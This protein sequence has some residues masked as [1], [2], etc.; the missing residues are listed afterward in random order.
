[1]IKMGDKIFVFLMCHVTDREMG[2]QPTDQHN[3]SVSVTSDN[4]LWATEDY[5]KFKTEYRCEGEAAS[6]ERGK[7]M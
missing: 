5:L 3:S 4:K 7:R 2:R 6:D 1:M